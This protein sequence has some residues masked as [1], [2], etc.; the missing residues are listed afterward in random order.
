MTLLY[1]SLSRLAVLESSPSTPKRTPRAWMM[2]FTS[3]LSKALCHC[4][5]ST[6][7]IFPLRARIAWNVLIRPFLAEPP[8]ESPSTRNIS[9]LAGSF[10]EQ[11]ANLP[12]RPPPERGLFLLSVSLARRAAIRTLAAKITL[13]IISLASLGCSSK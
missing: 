11:S 3:S 9:H 7:R 10:S 1:L 13:S 12:G 8:A 4:W 6:L 2:L 5:R